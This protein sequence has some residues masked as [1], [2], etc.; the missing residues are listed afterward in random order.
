M[1]E[2]RRAHAHK[3]KGQLRPVIPTEKTSDRAPVLEG[4][5]GAGLFLAR[6][7]DAPVVTTASLAHRITGT[8]QGS[9]RRP[10]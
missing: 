8:R 10:Q 9:Q 3:E 5:D 4:Y 7:R 2:R 6:V 1:R